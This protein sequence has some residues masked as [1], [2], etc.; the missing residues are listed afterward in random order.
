MAPNPE[1]T[2]IVQWRSEFREHEK[3][4]IPQL[5]SEKGMTCVRLASG[6][7]DY[8]FEKRRGDQEDDG[9][10][11]IC[12]ITR[13]DIIARINQNYKMT[14]SEKRTARDVA[15]RRFTLEA[16]MEAKNRGIDARQRDVSRAAK[17]IGMGDNPKNWESILGKYH[18]PPPSSEDNSST[19]VYSDP[20]LH[21]MTEDETIRYNQEKLDSLEE[22][23]R[24]SKAAKEKSKDKTVVESDGAVFEEGEAVAEPIEAKGEA[25]A[26]PIE[27]K[28]EAVAEPMIVDC[29]AKDAEREEKAVAD[30]NTVK[31]DDTDA[32]AKGDASGTSA[33]A[34]MAGSAPTLDL[35]LSG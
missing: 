29:D 33:I 8:V 32:V 11:A 25:V 3:D 2:P 14:K 5:L 34:L 21:F 1:P 10:K 28:G 23:L 6:A 19:G 12:I 31:G 35:G 20:D 16:R 18:R 27:E 26:E 17:A 22:R 13:D 30:S 4:L 24:E 15:K 7:I 9:Q